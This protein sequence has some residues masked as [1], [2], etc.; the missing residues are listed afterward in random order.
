MIALGACVEFVI[1][2]SSSMMHSL[3]SISQLVTA[4]LSASE[5]AVVGVMF[6]GIL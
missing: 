2:S 4:S 3:S 6:A 5:E 1:L